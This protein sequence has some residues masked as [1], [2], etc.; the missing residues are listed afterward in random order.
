VAGKVDCGFSIRIPRTVRLSNVNDLEDLADLRA[1]CLESMPDFEMCVFG[2]A[3]CTK[4]SGGANEAEDRD[5]RLGISCIEPLP[6]AKTSQKHQC[7]F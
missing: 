4:V 1:F 6:V 2:V 3:G 7:Y 5:D